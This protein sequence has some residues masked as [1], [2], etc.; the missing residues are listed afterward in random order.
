VANALRGYALV[1][2]DLHDPA[3]AVACW[4][5]ARG[6]YVSAGVQAGV[7]EAEKHIAQMS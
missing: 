6:L 5:E 1:L 4:A 7:D 2:D 3:A